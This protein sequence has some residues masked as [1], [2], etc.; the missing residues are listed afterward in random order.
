MK[1]EVNALVKPKENC[2]LNI[3]V[4][5]LKKSLNTIGWDIDINT[6][7][8]NT[9][10]LDRLEGFRQSDFLDSFKY[11]IFKV[12]DKYDFLPV[13]N[14]GMAIHSIHNVAMETNLFEFDSV[15]F[16]CI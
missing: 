3:V 13:S 1:I 16:N 5:S 9:K 4:S 8:H 6:F 2:D 10:V 14:E 7:K 15:K 12:T 11:T